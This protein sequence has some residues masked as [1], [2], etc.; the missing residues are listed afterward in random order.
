MGNLG[1]GMTL[2]PGFNEQTCPYVLV[3]ED[4][5][6]CLFNPFQNLYTSLLSLVP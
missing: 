1:L 4:T 6:L 3:K 2:L 5:H